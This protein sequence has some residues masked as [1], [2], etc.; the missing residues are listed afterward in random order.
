MAQFMSPAEFTLDVWREV[1]RAARAGARLGKRAGRLKFLIAAATEMTGVDPR[2][3][4]RINPVRAE[5]TRK[6][7]RVLR[8]GCTGPTLPEVS[9]ERASVRPMSALSCSAR[10]LDRL[11]IE[12]PTRT[13]TA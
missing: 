6:G 2:R 12:R 4:F 3:T 1:G 8:V 7:R 11:L 13:I 5:N 10:V 9:S